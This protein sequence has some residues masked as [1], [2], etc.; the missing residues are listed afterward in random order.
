[1]PYR[2]QLGAHGSG[3][4]QS[5]HQPH[6]QRNQ[7]A[8]SPVK[9]FFELFSVLADFKNI[10]TVLS[11]SGKGFVVF[12]FGKQRRELLLNIL[13]RRLVV[14]FC[15]P[16]IGFD[17]I[18]SCAHVHIEQHHIASKLVCQPVSCTFKA[19][20]GIPFGADRHDEAIGLLNTAKLLLQLLFFKGT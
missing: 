7:D 3:N 19:A 6:N 16:A 1:M 17:P 10:G 4:N 12:P 5:Q 20:F 8:D 15:N 13:R 9:G 14:Q 18:V 2:F 11:E